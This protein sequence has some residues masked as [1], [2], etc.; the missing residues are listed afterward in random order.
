MRN[1]IISFAMAFTMT[2][3]FTA[4]LGAQAGIVVKAARGLSD[5]PLV[6]VRTPIGPNV[7]ANHTAIIRRGT[8]SRT[9]AP[10]TSSTHAH[11][12]Y[13]TYSVDVNQCSTR[14]RSV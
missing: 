13:A 14:P 7:G 2:G 4:M 10:I 11:A 1:L 12:R 5:A 3:M 8:R 9:V 6:D